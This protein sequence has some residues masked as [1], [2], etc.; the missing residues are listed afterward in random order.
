MDSSPKETSFEYGESY[1]LEQVEKHRERNSNHWKDRV[2]LAHS[3]IDKWVLPNLDAS[4]PKNIRTLDV[5]CSIGT[6]AIEMAQ[7]GFDSF[8]VDFD[9][10]A[11]KLARMLADEENVSI[12]FFQCDVAE[13]ENKEKLFDIVLCFDI[14][15]HL[16]DDELGSL[17]QSIKRQLSANGALLFYSFPLQY[18]YLFYSR[19]LLHWPL[20]PFKWLSTKGFERVVRFYASVLDAG[21]LLTTGKLYKDRIA[22]I[23]HCNPTTKPR[24]EAI[25]QRAGYSIEFFETDNI[26]PFKQKVKKRFSNQPVADRNLFGVAKLAPNK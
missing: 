24:L 11:L 16:H 9:E 4:D 26:Y 17:L 25:L 15:E 3:M 14:F 10:S 2:G 21:L 8:G 12:E 18:D 5:G 20:I 19:D 6:M 23:S 13:L 1:Q 7:R 22:K